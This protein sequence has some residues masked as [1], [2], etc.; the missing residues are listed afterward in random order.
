MERCPTGLFGEKCL[1]GI[2][3][4]SF[5]DTVDFYGISGREDLKL[6]SNTR[7]MLVLI[8]KLQKD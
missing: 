1:Q 3:A 8:Q 7:R 4:C 2:L 5:S 6:Q